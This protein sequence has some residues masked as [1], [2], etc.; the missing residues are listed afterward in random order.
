MRFELPKNLKRYMA[1]KG[2]VALDGVSLTVTKIG[3]GFFETVLIPHTLKTAHSG[4]KKGHDPINLEVD[5]VARY[6]QWRNYEV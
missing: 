5:L 4:F 2:S 1:L 6:I 3:K